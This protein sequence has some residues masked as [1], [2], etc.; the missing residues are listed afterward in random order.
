LTPL[1][2]ALEP[3]Q[4]V[5][6]FYHYAANDPLREGLAGGHAGEL[7]VISVFMAVFIPCAFDRRELAA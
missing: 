2:G 7:I 1:V 6:P 3:L 5:S 4:N